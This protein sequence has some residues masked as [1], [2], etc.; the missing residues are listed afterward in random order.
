M[1][2]ATA[3]SSDS[4]FSAANKQTS[5][6]TLATWNEEIWNFTLERVAFDFPHR[7]SLRG[8]SA[9]AGFGLAL[10]ERLH[11]PE[12]FVTE[13]QE[14]FPAVFETREVVTQFL[15]ERLGKHLLAAILDKKGLFDFRSQTPL[16]FKPTKEVLLLRDEP[17]YVWVPGGKQ[18]HVLDFKLGVANADKPV[19][20]FDR[21]TPGEK[22]V[23]TEAGFDTDAK[24]KV[25]LRMSGVVST[26]KI[27][28][29]SPTGVMSYPKVYMGDYPWPNEMVAAIPVQ[30]PK[31]VEGF[32]KAKAVLKPLTHELNAGRTDEM[33]YEWVSRDDFTP[34]M[35]LAEIERLSTYDVYE[36]F[37][38]VNPMAE[39]IVN[40]VVARLQGL[41]GLGRWQQE[42]ISDYP[43]YEPYM[44]KPGSCFC[45]TGKCRTATCPCFAANEWCT[46][47][48]HFATCTTAHKW[49]K[50]DG[51][52]THCPEVQEV[53]QQRKRN[54]SSDDDD[55][56]PLKRARGAGSADP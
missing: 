20:I 27:K 18:S 17:L 29:I 36:K 49:F 19:T 5:I 9:P 52:C 44:G 2:T 26:D 38:E 53:I 41:E 13:L 37:M 25:W 42:S 43:P 4:G 39:E 28:G 35:I 1:W 40:A 56:A 8:G 11:L 31:V 32:L 16:A 51:D 50:V 47:A 6:Q 10:H 30:S 3:S 33:N 46:D 45:I 54:A 34:E 22:G 48:C 15:V 55:F 24:Q 14:K 23:L 21:L 12:E 7:R